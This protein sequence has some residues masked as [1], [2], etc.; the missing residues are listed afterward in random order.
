MS[1]S[2]KS[3]HVEEG[4]SKL[5]SQFR[6]KPKI[7]ALSTVYI[8]QFQ[9]LEDALSDLLTETNLDNATGIH[10]DNIGAIVGEPRLGRDDTQYRTAIGT[11]ILLNTSNGTIE[12]IIGIMLS[13]L[14]SSASAT[15]T[16]FFPA[17]F[18]AEI[19]TTVDLA[20]TDV[21]Q[22]ASL[23][24]DGRPTGVRGLLAFH[25]TEVRN[26]FTMGSAQGLIGPISG[27]GVP[28]GSDTL[29]VGSTNGYP[30][31][32]VLSIDPTGTPETVSYSSKNATTF[33]LSGS[34]TVL[35]LA[36]VTVQTGDSTDRGFSD[37]G[38]PLTGGAFASVTESV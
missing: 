2:K 31:V 27:P 4:I 5:I 7:V 10:L 22:I 30:D 32:G 38:A 26:S 23:I 20:I 25:T 34:T 19:D 11:R 17:A 36:G 8:Q 6:D 3:N 14:G 12:D 18:I 13:T 15:I 28:I 33:F 9:E 35:H 21:D 37:T 16:E 1:Y 29:I 24:T